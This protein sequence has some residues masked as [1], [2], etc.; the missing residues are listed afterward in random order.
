MIIKAAHHFSQISFA[1]I[2]PGVPVKSFS[3]YLV[4]VFFNRSVLQ[5]KIGK[6]FPCDKVRKIYAALIKPRLAVKNILVFFL[7]PIN[8][9]FA[10]NEYCHASHFCPQFLKFQSPVVLRFCRGH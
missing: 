2:F 5:L 4:E 10:V 9:V 1:V 6:L 3:H 8:M 7:K